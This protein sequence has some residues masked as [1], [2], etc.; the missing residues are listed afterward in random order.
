M[1]LRL[2]QVQM[3]QGLV[4]GQVVVFL[5]RSSFLTLCGDEPLA[6][7]LLRRLDDFGGWASEE[8]SIPPQQEQSLQMAC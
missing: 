8:E 6:T 7:A 3:H 1:G 2:R 4:L 5:A